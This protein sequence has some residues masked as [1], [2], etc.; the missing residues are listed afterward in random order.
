MYKAYALDYSLE[1]KYTV[2]SKRGYCDMGSHQRLVPKYHQDERCGDAN[3][4]CLTSNQINIRLDQLGLFATGVKSCVVAMGFGATGLFWHAYIQV[5]DWTRGWAG[6]TYSEDIKDGKV[7]GCSE[8][9]R[10]DD[11][12]MPDGTPCSCASAQK[13][14]ECVKNKD[15]WPYGEYYILGRNCG[16]WVKEV[17]NRFCMK[18][19]FRAPWFAPNAEGLANIGGPIFYGPSYGWKWPNTK[20]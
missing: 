8:M 20:K 4:Y 13:L 1:P 10:R 9:E 12:N 19:K 17:A 2:Q 14:Q 11:G 15:N 7:R 5:E 6:F 16:A 3:L 18:A